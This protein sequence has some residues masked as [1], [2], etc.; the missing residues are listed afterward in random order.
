MNGLEIIDIIEK[1]DRL[2]VMSSEITNIINMISDM[3]T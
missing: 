1:S 2:P 3:I